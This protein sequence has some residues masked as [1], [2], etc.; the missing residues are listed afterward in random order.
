M[1]FCI[2]SRQKIHVVLKEDYGLHEVYQDMLMT[3]EILQDQAFDLPCMSS[4]ISS[5]SLHMNILL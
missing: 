2:I 5:I 3:H 4:S 1:P